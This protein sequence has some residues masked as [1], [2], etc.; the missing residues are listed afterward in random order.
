[1]RARDSHLDS[2]YLIYNYK[3]G[4]FF[5]NCSAPSD[6]SL[7]A[8]WG[9]IT[10]ASCG[11]GGRGRPTQSG[12]GHYR[13]SS[14]MVVAV[15]AAWQCGWASPYTLESVLDGVRSEL[16]SVAQ[17]TEAAQG[18]IA[19]RCDIATNLLLKFCINSLG[20][21]VS[22][23]E[24]QSVRKSIYAIRTATPSCGSQRFLVNT[25]EEPVS[26]PMIKSSA[27]GQTSGAAN[28]TQTVVP[29]GCKHATFVTSWSAVGAI[30]PFPQESDVIVAML[31][32][33]QG[34]YGIVEEVGELQT[35]TK[36]SRA[37]A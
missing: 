12:T 16:T 17:G 6:Q 22:E 34:T 2:T 37:H 8:V 26:E 3:S 23:A 36:A 24:S 20:A 29:P 15:Y 13:L 5:F 35:R 32:W 11:P 9:N 27:I 1:M 33:L 14:Q 18:D 19:L 21:P 4:A 25:A 30:Q 28:Y 10:A 7:T 31:Q